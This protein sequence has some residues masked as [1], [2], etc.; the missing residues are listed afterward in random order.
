MSAAPPSELDRALL[1]ELAEA[2]RHHNESTFGGA[3]RAPIFA[4]HDGADLG[5]YEAQHR[6]LSIQR[7]L[8]YRAPWGQVI[9]V[10]RHEQAHQFVIEAMRVRGE[11]PHGP[12]FR[13]VCAQRGIDARAA[14]LPATGDAEIGR[15]LRKVRG[16]LALS[17]SDN[18]HESQAAARA[19]RR[20][21]AEHDLTLTPDSSTYTFR[22]IGPARQRF[23][24]HEKMLAQV[25]L[26]HFG[27]R[28]IYANAYL[29]TK[30]RWGRVLEIAG[31]PEHVEVAA[32]MY[33][34]L[35]LHAERAWRAWK[36]AKNVDRNRDRQRF[37][38]G[39]MRGFHD[40]LDADSTADAGSALIHLEDPDLDRYFDRRHPR[41]QKSGGGT[42]RHTEAVDAGVAAGGKLQ[43]YRGVGGDGGAPR[44]ITER[45]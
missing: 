9:E 15:L 38:Y 14:G 36:K 7:D 22:Q 16:L 41:I 17:Q 28:V 43:I 13:R 10:L 31:S 8:A 18:P 6:T 35:S 5:R 3:M 26:V 11:P 20:L 23:P 34:A 44:Q 45:S 24:L 19:A 21:L 25:L 12:T 42:Y 32:Y 33:D 1:H 2:W 37:L 29:P 39:V 40:A 30:R 27:V 4:L